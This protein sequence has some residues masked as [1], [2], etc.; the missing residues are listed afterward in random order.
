MGAGRRSSPERAHPTDCHR[1]ARPDHSRGDRAGTPEREKLDEVRRC[2][3]GEAEPPLTLSQPSSSAAFA[4]ARPARGGSRDRAR[5]SEDAPRRSRR[6]RR[7]QPGSPEKE[8]EV[9]QVSTE[10]EGKEVSRTRVKTES[11]RGSRSRSGSPRVYGV[12]GCT[13]PLADPVTSEESEDLSGR[14]GD[15]VH[16][17]YPGGSTRRDTRRQLPHEL[18]EAPSRRAQSRHR[19]RQQGWGQRQ[20]GEGERRLRERQERKV[21]GKEGQSDAYEEPFSE[22]ESL[23]SVDESP[24]SPLS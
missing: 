12:A 10:G 14:R 17:F 16:A 18:A 20:I 4:V 1:G 19:S 22:C 21:E 13:R 3:S 7:S 15:H 5:R 9:S 6:L 23:G 24:K 11:D 8:R 2:S